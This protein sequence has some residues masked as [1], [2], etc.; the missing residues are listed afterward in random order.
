M[1]SLICNERL[2]ALKLPSLFCRRNQPN[3]ILLHKIMHNLIDTDL[4]KLFHLH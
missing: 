4:S 2:V 1:K 3:L